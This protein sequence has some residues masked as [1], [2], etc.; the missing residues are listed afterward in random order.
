VKFSIVTPSYKQLD[1]LRLCVASV[2]DQAA[3]KAESGNLKAETKNEEPL[4]LWRALAYGKRGIFHRA[5]HSPSGRTKNAP[6]PLAVEHII[7]D[8]GTPGIEDFAREINADF[9]QDGQLVSRS[10][11]SALSSSPASTLDSPPATRHPLLVTRPYRIAIYCERDAGM[12][13]AINRG[14]SKATG[15]VVAWLN[16]DEQYLPGALRFTTDFFARH[17]KTDMIFGDAI[18]LDEHC[19]PYSYRRV[20]LPSMDYLRTV[21]PSL[22]SCAAFFRHRVVEAGILF[23][24]QWRIIGDA[25][26]FHD[27]LRAGFKART[28]GKPIAGFALTGDNLSALEESSQLEWARWRAMQTRPPML[29]RSILVAIHRLKKMLGG[30]YVTRTMDVESFKHNHFCQRVLYKNC[31]LG[32]SWEK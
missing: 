1:W 5:K 19:H 13:D 8:A 26:W 21:S 17:T 29:P 31:Q 15:D 25:V 9:Y 32:S 12:Y 11:V 24:P 20:V 14:F 30:A 3:E 7:Q 4:A 22:F 6:P 28:V 16:C 18:M 23:D 27:L 10:Q 2:R